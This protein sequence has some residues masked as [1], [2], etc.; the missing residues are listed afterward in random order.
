MNTYYYTIRNFASNNGR[1]NKHQ[2]AETSETVNNFLMMLSWLGIRE[3][4]KSGSF[5]AVVVKLLSVTQET[6]E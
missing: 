4:S 2:K 5:L 6:R 3:S 1:K